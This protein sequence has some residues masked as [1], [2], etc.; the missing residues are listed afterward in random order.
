M[1]ILVPR[2]RNKKRGCTRIYLETAR[3]DTFFFFLL[4]FVLQII[5]MRISV[6]EIQRCIIVF[7]FVAQDLSVTGLL[8]AF[9]FSFFGFPMT[10]ETTIK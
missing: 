10:K 5:K 3:K 4:A 2:F 7:L 8:L 1:Q 9:C 6:A